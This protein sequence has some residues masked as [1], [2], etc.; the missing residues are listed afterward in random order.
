VT[1][2]RTRR[3][4]RNQALYRQVNER[5]ED[6]NEAFDVI[7]HDFCVV[8]ECGDLECVEQIR[9]SR[10]VYEQ[11]RANP[12]LFIV[13]PGHDATDVDR[14]VKRTAEYAIIAKDP[15]DAVRIAEKTDPRH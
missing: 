4:G 2:E 1:D 13:R 9:V 5:I 14:V 8:C 3:V 15:P 6:L 12:A 10:E 11:T 7:T